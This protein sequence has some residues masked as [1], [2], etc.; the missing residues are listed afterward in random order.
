M[1]G[2]DRRRKQCFTLSRRID[3]SVLQD[4]VGRSAC[5]GY[6]STRFQQL[7]N[8]NSVA[9]LTMQARG[10]NAQARPVG[11]EKGR[12]AGESKVY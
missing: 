4:D 5:C 1:F 9:V 8:G 11:V 7:A 3:A 10:G 2:K 6:K 12:R